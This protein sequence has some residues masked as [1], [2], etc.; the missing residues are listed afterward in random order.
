[1]GAS[2][3]AVTCMMHNVLARRVFSVPTLITSYPVSLS[4]SLEQVAADRE[5][6][7]RNYVRPADEV[8]AERA[9]SIVERRKQGKEGWAAWQGGEV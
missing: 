1:M 6:R 4:E 8:V 9:K 7:E 5:Q 3:A 2:P